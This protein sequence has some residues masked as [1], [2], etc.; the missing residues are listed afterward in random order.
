M[1]NENFYPN[2]IRVFYANLTVENNV[3]L[4]RVNDIDI[5]MSCTDLAE[6]LEIDNEGREIFSKTLDN[7]KDFPI[8]HTSLFAST[9]IHSDPNPSLIMNENVDLLTSIYQ[10]IAKIIMYN[11]VPSPCQF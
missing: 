1:I 4:S 7:F 3:L 8:D 11:I 5:K 6:F 9:L 2:L 10:A